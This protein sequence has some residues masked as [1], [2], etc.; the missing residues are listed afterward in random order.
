MLKEVCETSF[1]FDNMEQI[2]EVLNKQ[3]YTAAKTHIEHEKGLPWELLNKKYKLYV[4]V[5]ICEEVPD[6]TEEEKDA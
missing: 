1:V 5:G 3:M 4:S 6:K 2:T